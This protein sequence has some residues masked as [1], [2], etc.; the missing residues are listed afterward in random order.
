MLKLIIT[1][2]EKKVAKKQLEIQTTVSEDQIAYTFT[3]TLSAQP[4][5]KLL[6]QKIVT[7]RLRLA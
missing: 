4:I 1:L 6:A 2:S 7:L 5:Q 3:K